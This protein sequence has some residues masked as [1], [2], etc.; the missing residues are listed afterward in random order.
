[1]G[2]SASSTPLYAAQLE[3]D[4]ADKDA[5]SLEQLEFQLTVAADVQREKALILRVLLIIEIC[6]ALVIVREI[7]LLFWI[8]G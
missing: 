4:L 2:D 6:L 3:G 5:S 8:D 1:M 7:I